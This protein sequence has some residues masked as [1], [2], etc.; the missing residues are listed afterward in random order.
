MKKSN[1]FSSGNFDVYVRQALERHAERRRQLHA[2]ASKNEEHCTISYIG[3][4]E[5]GNKRHSEMLNLQAKVQQSLIEIQ[6]Q[7]K[8]ARP[9]T[10]PEDPARPRLRPSSS[11]KTSIVLKERPR[12][13]IQH[14]KSAKKPVTP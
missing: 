2:S 12:S 9:E 14:S 7:L 11:H 6:Q 8:T 10:L 5:M 1:D 4:E 3:N 13:S